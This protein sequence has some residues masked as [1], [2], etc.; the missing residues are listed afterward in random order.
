MSLE[1][2]KT[3]G[4]V[5][6][7]LMV[8]GLL[9]FFGAAY[10][11]IL[12]LVGI[13]LVLIAL[14]GLADHYQE[15][16]IFNNALY[17]FITIILGGVACIAVIVV[18]VMTMVLP[19]IDLSDPS[20]IQ[21]YFMDINNLWAFVGSLIAAFVLLFVFV[22]VSAVLFRKSLDS[23]SAKSGEKL[24][25]TAGLLWLI[26][27]ILF[28]VFFVGVILIWISWILM[29]VAFFSMKTAGQPTAAQPPQPPP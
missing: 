28:I 15:S 14:K 27:A 12:C 23:L 7:I 17:G 26:G 18:M 22:V 25:R 11:L 24:F 16:S 2:N 8:V 19:G 10:A 5:G 13:I 1:T 9:G 21:R 20:A 4:G 6:A 3:L 29:A